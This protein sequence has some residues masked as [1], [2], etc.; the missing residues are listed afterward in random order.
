[1]TGVQV[2]HA[3]PGGCR[4]QVPPV[5]FAC[6]WCWSRLPLSRDEGWTELVTAEDRHRA[7]RAPDDALFA[8]R[9]RRAYGARTWY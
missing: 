6:R 9:R 2:T 4:R 1:M 3:C 5:C 7:A 8:L